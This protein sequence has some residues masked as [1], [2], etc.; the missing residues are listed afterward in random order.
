MHCAASDVT[1]HA[2]NV[3]WNDDSGCKTYLFE[4]HDKHKGPLLLKTQDR[5]VVVEKPICPSLF[6]QISFRLDFGS[7]QTV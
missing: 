5:W 4:Q 7:V 3:I 6:R 1:I 2:Q